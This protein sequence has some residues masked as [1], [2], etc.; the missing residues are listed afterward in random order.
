MKQMFLR[1]VGNNDS[2]TDIVVGQQRFVIGRHEDA[3]FR[4]SSDLV[5]RRHCVIHFSEGQFIIE[6]LDS[7]NGT[8]INGQRIDGKQIANNG[9]TLQLGRLLFDMII[10]PSGE[11]PSESN[12]DGADLGVST[13]DLQEEARQN[14][15]R[16]SSPPTIDA[17][18]VLNRFFDLGD[19]SDD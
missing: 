1:L 12:P 3:D 4:P 7:R 6:D 17:N 2:S 8:F 10:T 14:R 16:M 18:R 9:C 15:N 19:D 13:H 11:N 5:S